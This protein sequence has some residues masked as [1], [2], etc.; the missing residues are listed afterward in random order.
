[1]TKT[2]ATTPVEDWNRTTAA[3]EARMPS[4]ESSLVCM[5]GKPVAGLDAIQ[6]S[7]EKVRLIRVVTDFERSLIS[8]VEGNNRRCAI[9][10][11]FRS[12]KGRHLRSFTV[13][14]PITQ[15]YFEL[16]A[17]GS[18]VREHFEVTDDGAGST[19]A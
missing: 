5:D 19:D 7:D 10:V 3:L 4:A 1:M 9:T 13:I 15:H 2:K 14:G 8:R 6:V 18:L 16:R 17:D 12:R 11:T